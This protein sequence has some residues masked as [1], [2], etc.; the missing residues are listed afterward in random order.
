MTQ[1]LGL[2]MN[3]VSHH[4][5]ILKKAGLVRAERDTQDR[6]WIYYEVVPEALTMLRNAIYAALDPGRLKP[7]S[8]RC[9]P[10]ACSSQPG[11]VARASSTASPRGK[12]DLAK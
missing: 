1:A 2:P 5:G 3:L 11:R 7:R 10:P 9:G 6:R 8:E 4:L 12:R